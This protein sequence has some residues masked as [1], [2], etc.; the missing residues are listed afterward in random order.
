[1]E[2][3]VLFFYKYYNSHIARCSCNTGIHWSQANPLRST[4]SP[5]PVVTPSFSEVGSGSWVLCS[6]CCIHTLPLRS[7]EEHP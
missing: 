6:H 3:L 7:R 5:P 1:M 4:M 2:Q